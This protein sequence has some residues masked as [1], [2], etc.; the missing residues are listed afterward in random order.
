[1]S[2]A[3]RHE[4]D[5][6]LSGDAPAPAG[7]AERPGGLL[8]SIAQTPMVETIFRVRRCVVMVCLLSCRP[9]SNWPREYR[10]KE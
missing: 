1:M 2:P 6:P 9:V 8:S 5:P 10:R 7:K 4:G 3:E